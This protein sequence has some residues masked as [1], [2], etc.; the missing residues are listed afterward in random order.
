[1]E[2]NNQV[3]KDKHMIVKVK[4]DRIYGVDKYYPANKLARLAVDLAKTKQVT[5]GMIQCLK[6]YGYDVQVVSETETL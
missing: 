6:D 3:D 1:M 5:D 4:R 2:T